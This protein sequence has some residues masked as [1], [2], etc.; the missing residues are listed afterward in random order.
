VHFRLNPTPR[1]PAPTSNPFL[2]LLLLRISQPRNSSGSRLAITQYSTPRRSTI[3]FV[4]QFTSIFRFI[5]VSASFFLPSCRRRPVSIFFET[6]AQVCKK[7]SFFDLSYLL[8]M[9]FRLLRRSTRS[10]AASAGSGVIG[11]SGHDFVTFHASL[12]TLC[13]CRTSVNSCVLVH[14]PREGLQAGCVDVGISAICRAS[15]PFAV[16]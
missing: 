1:P 5:T 6:D 8:F 7:I 13:R 11:H 12:V 4:S 14:V 16:R 9:C 15:H 2:F 3:V 10:S